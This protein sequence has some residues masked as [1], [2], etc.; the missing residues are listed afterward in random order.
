MGKQSADNILRC[1]FFFFLLFTALSFQAFGLVWLSLYCRHTSV[2]FK[3]L[4]ILNIKIAC[5]ITIVTVFSLHFSIWI[6]LKGL[7]DNMRAFSYLIFIPRSYTEVLTPYA[8][9]EYLNHLVHAS[10]LV[11]VR[12]CS[13]CR[14]MIL[15]ANNRHPGLNIYAGWFWNSVFLNLPFSWHELWLILNKDAKA[16][17]GLAETCQEECFKE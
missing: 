17:P 5:D 7:I 14:T 4:I 6:S 13:L 15:Q 12:R 16:F 9:T 2:C 10:N 11:D 1:I 3:Q 8:N